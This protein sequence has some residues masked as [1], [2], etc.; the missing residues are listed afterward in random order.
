[1]KPTISKI[2]TGIDAAAAKTVRLLLNVEPQNSAVKTTDRLDFMATA[3]P[4][5]FI[6]LRSKTMRLEKNLLG[7][8]VL[9]RKE[10]T[11]G[12]TNCLAAGSFT[13]LFFANLESGLFSRNPE[14]NLMVFSD[15]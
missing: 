4:E 13:F 8:Q 10:H 6:S 2:L 5:T 3:N 9:A 14:T 12:N 1:M 15:N 7:I 11:N